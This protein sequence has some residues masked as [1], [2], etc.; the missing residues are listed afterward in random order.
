MKRFS[1]QIVDL[2]KTP[3]KLPKVGEIVLIYVNDRLTKGWYVGYYCEYSKGG[4]QVEF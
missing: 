4:S 2:R 3:D 1:R